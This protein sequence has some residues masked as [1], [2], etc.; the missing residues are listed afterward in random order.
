M[1]LE[2]KTAIITGAAGGIGL[3]ISK[4]FAAEGCRV[5][6]ADLDQQ[7]VAA[8]AAEIGA[9][10]IGVRCDVS[11]ETE[12]AEA[13]RQAKER[14]GGVDIVVN[15]AGLMTFAPLEEL[16]QADWIRILGV[17]L[18][19]AFF[20]TRELLKSAPANGAIVNISSVH[21]VQTTPN[22]APYAAAKAALLSLTRSTAIEGAP[23]RVRAN[24]ILP[25]AI[26]TPMLWNNPN[27]K[28]GAEVVDR[29]EVGRPEDI[30]ATAAFLASD[31][32]AFITGA[33]FNVDGGRLA[34]L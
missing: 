31:D 25:G 7:K 28:S 30:A 8:A 23:K 6:L 13:Y 9:D 18:L 1:R 21:A 2:H 14:F 17:D 12:V 19:G 20:F 33:A 29:R 4:R 16:T 15:N 22:V 27:V 5:A 32:A 3:A 11:S 10:A 34:Q 24:A 26:D